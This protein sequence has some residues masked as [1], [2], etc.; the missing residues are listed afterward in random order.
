MAQHRKGAVVYAAQDAQK[1]KDDFWTELNHR[2]LD[3]GLRPSL[4]ALSTFTDVN[5]QTISNY[6]T[7]HS[8][9]TVSV[10]QKLVTALKPDIG[11]VLRFLGYSDK[12]IKKFAKEVTA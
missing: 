5:A 8:P 1:A 3:M 10:M 11:V 7:G 2:L 9:M 6:R 4:A 12:E